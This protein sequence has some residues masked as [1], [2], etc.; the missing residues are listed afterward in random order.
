[1]SPKCEI[2]AEYQIPLTSKE[3]RAI[4]SPTDVIEEIR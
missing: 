3:G 1:M 4:A 2:L